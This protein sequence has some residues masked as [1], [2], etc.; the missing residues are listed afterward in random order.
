MLI[1]SPRLRPE[2]RAEWTA[3]ERYDIRLA[4]L[5][6]DR[7]ERAR[8]AVRSFLADGDAYVAVSWG[9][10]SVVVAHIA[11]QVDHHVRIEWV[12]ARDVETPE[13]AAVRDTFLAQHPEVR[14]REHEAV[15]RIPLRGEPGYD[16]AARQDIL[17]EHLTGRR[18][19][20]IRAAE[21]RTRALSA[22]VHGVATAVS[23]RPI[24]GWSDQDVFS[25]A[26]TEGLPLH[27][28][29]AMSAGGSIDRH[30]LRVH[31]LRTTPPYITAADIVTRRW[32]KW[33]DLY[34]ADV[35]SRPR[36]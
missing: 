24:I 22:A 31:A 12:R 28:A 4:P 20:G 1:D 2:D 9:K 33:E 29:Y 7:P 6:G 18:I 25:F 10:D 17:G 21:S 26:A 23:C 14:Y 8:L 27:P 34:Y 30:D 35:V 32:E 15:F 16:P 3:L 36:S 13:T 19:S 5:L 11:A